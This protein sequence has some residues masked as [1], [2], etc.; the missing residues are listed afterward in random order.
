L[1][2]LIIFL[3]SQISTATKVQCCTNC[4]FKGFQTAQF[5]FCRLHVFLQ[6]IIAVARQRLPKRH[7]PGSITRGRLF[8]FDAA[9]SYLRTVNKYSLRSVVL[10]IGASVPVA[11]ATYGVSFLLLQVY[12]G[13]LA[14]DYGT[15]T[16]Y[17]STYQPTEILVFDAILLFLA[18]GALLLGSGGISRNTSRAAK[19]AS[20]AKA[21][22][23]ET[24]GA[25]EIMRRDAW[26]PKGHIRAGLTLVM[27]GIFLIILSFVLLYIP[28]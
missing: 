11:L 16:S 20:V 7:N 19:I 21:F 12:L 28:L 3:L 15:S 26:K 27:A 18:G 24:V 10:L 8:I 9:S 13:A 22:G 1:A 14:S 4:N 5:S 6:K 25:S 17:S 23:N 2:F